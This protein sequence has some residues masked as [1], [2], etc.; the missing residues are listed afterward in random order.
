[1]TL[2]VSLRTSDGIVIAGDS[3]STMRVQMGLATKI[4]HKCSSCGH[5]EEMDIRYPPGELPLAILPMM[6]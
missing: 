3:L 2:I 6:G 5:E 4:Q 1:M